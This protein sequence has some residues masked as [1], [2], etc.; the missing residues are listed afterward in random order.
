MRLSALLGQVFAALDEAGSDFEYL[1]VQNRAEY[2]PLV[3]LKV[4]AS[5]LGFIELLRTSLDAH[6]YEVEIRYDAV[7]IITPKPA[8]PFVPSVSPP[9]P[10][11][12]PGSSTQN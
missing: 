3:T 5:F 10:V 4:D 11:Q 9:P 8:A 1:Y 6:G 12:N 7:V 2:D